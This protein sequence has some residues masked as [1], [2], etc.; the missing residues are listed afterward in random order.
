VLWGLAHGVA[1]VLCQWFQRRRDKRPVGFPAR[2]G[3]VGRSVAWVVTFHFVML[4]FVLV[5]HDAADALRIYAIL[6]GVSD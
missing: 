6:L 4:S 3:I 1:I 5:Q 2:S